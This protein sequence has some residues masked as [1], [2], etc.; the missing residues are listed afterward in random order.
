[1]AALQPKLFVLFDS[2]RKKASGIERQG[3]CR[4]SEYGCYGIESTWQAKKQF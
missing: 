3:V 1:M 2:V 4:S